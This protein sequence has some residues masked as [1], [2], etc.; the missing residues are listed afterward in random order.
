MPDEPRL[1]RV[2]ITGLAYVLADDER[3]AA[4]LV[5]DALAPSDYDLPVSCS[6][7]LNRGAAPDPAWT[8][9]LPLGEDDEERTVAEIIAAY[10]PD[11]QDMERAGQMRL[12][13][14]A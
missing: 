1:Y 6:A 12:E 8:D 7:T 14:P 3:A 10:V 11:Q 5:E 13:E 9:S 2:H 4:K